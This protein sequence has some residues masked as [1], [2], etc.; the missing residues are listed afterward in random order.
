MKI[1]K[2]EAYEA[3]EKIESVGLNYTNRYDTDNFIRL[4]N[5]WYSKYKN[6]LEELPIDSALTHILEN[7]FKQTY[8]M[9][10]E[11]LELF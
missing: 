11:Q 2:I 1:T 10:T 5:I 8:G 7:E 4:N 6:N 9:I 3:I